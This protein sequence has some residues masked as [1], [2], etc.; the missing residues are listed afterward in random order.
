MQ[1]SLTDLR[2]FVAIAELGSL[3]RAAERHHLSLPAVSQRIQAMEKQASCRLLERQARGVRLTA[4]GEAFANHAR[5]MLLEG[6]ALRATLSAF[7]EGLQGHLTVLANT[8]AVTELMPAVLAQ[9]LASHP[10]VSVSLRE[11]AN[12]EVARAVRE[13]RA[14]LG[15]VAGD[16][17]LA[18]LRT[19]HFATD[20]LVLVT[21]RGHPLDGCKQ[22]AFADCLDLPMVGLYET[23]TIQAFLR[24]R[25]VA[26]D[27]TPARPR[28]QVNSFEAVCL[29][30]EAGVG[31]AIVPDS[32]ARRYG[33][34]Q[35]IA[36][37]PLTDPWALRHRYVV[38][39]DTPTCPAYLDDLVTAICQTG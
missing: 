16:I 24:D 7:A 22:I 18:G 9:F 17:D 32:V 34:T 28:A 14:D 8:T 35:R 38:T 33:S 5:A 3:T 20:R 37:V 15:V 30:V 26:L 21:S 10:Q 27:R 29:M 13:S 11:Q 39:R 12:H 25:L 36:V 2:L 6:D 23:S 19:R 4:A 31:A 1:L